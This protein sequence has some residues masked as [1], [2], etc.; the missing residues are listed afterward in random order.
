MSI[1]RKIKFKGGFKGSYLFLLNI[2]VIYL[3]VLNICQFWFPQ[4]A[5]V[6]VKVWINTTRNIRIIQSISLIFLNIENISWVPGA[7]IEI[8]SCFFALFLKHFRPEDLRREF[9]RYGPV[10]DVY[11]PLDFYTRRPRGFAYIQY[12]LFHCIVIAVHCC[13]CILT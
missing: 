10:V 12:P 13:Y 1:T 9:G 6:V 8:H 3:K 5:K 11:I 7:I 2:I 4:V